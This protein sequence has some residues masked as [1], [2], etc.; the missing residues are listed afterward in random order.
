[1][2]KNTF[3]E[4]GNI[5]LEFTNAEFGDPRL[6]DRLKAMSMALM[7]DPSSS[8][9][10]VFGDSAGTE[11]CYRFLR[12]ERV[13]FDAILLPHQQQT[14]RR[15]QLETEVLIVHDT[16]EFRFSSPRQDLGLMTGSKEGDGFYGHFSL[17]LGGDNFKIPLGVINTQLYIKKTKKGY[18]SPAAQRKD[19][20]RKTLCWFE[21]V[22]Q[23]QKK[24]KESA[25]HVM[26][27]EADFFEHLSQLKDINARYV[28]RVCR[29][30]WVND[31]KT[32]L[33]Y[34]TLKKQEVRLEREVVVSKRAKSIFPNGQKDH[35]KREMRTARLIATAC[36][37]ELERG[38][39]HPRALN[40]TI[41]I[42][43][44]HVFEP[45]PPLGEEPVDWKLYTTQPIDSPEQISRVIDIYRARWTIEEYFKVLKTGCSYEERQLE[46]KKTLTNLLGIFIP[47]AWMLLNLRSQARSCP[48]A[49]ANEVFSESQISILKIKTNLKK[50]AEPTVQDVYRA[51]AALG[52]HLTQ[53]GPPGWLVLW[54]GMKKLLNLQEGWEARE[55]CDQ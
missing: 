15:A 10:D 20:T 5:A 23:S 38:H 9:P 8:L 12:N 49:P 25:I 42:N 43:V 11:G 48:S 16:S 2:I 54:R 19:P 31:E 13:C 17:A 40:K 30:R 6:A 44:V 46:S 36:Q 3:F 53:N 18:R 32:P 33:L 4:S 34:E 24:I 50:V 7:R 21:G 27:R 26:D 22:Q 28:I 39:H 45:S 35:P 41:A 51:V 29:D 52:G 1:M 55:R 47:I 14:M 37:V